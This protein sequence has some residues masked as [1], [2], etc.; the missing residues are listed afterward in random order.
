MGEPMTAS[1]VDQAEV[2]A[3]DALS[4]RW[5][6]PAG[7]FRSLH[8][9]NPTRLAFIRTR[10]D[11]HFG[12]VPRA[13]APF[14]G[15]RLLDIGCGGGLIAEPMARLGFAVTGIDAGAATI[16]AARRH[17]AASGL[18]ID[19]REG[20][21]E[22]LAAAGERFDAVLTLE[23]VEHAE[24]AA[25]FLAAA[26]DLVRP[27]GALILST[28]NRTAKAFL[29]GIVAAEY[30]LRWVA[31][32]THQWQRF[33]RPSE[34]AGHLRQH[35]MSVAEVAGLVFDLRGGWRLGEDKSVNYF[36]FATKPSDK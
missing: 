26:A 25:A 17:A 34:V 19:Y 6:D 22:T 32:G 10:L 33:L 35:G 36:V 20:A 28:L 18:A 15:R 3:F 11:R 29:L 31:P 23:V 2:A 4:A 1:T 30:V 5:W 13:L 7:P 16:A 14:Q 8:R 21:A 24:D 9:V 12:T 27:G